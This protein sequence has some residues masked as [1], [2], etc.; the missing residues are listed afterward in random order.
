MAGERG[1]AISNERVSSLKKPSS[2]QV[3]KMKAPFTGTNHAGSYQY[4]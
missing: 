2:T 3:D 1:V 4:K